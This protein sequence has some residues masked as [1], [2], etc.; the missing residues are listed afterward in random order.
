MVAD[1]EVGPR[2]RGLLYLFLMRTLFP[3]FMPDLE[4]NVS[5]VS[6]ARRPN[7]LELRGNAE[8]ALSI[9]PFERSRGTKLWGLNG[10]WASR[11]QGD[12]SGNGCGW[13]GKPKWEEGERRS[14]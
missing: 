13:G 10:G 1:S 4:R 8:G 14:T 3:P 5:A 6:E 2:A 12:A 9:Q 11:W 7:S